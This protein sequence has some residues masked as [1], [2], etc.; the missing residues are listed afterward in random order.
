MTRIYPSEIAFTIPSTTFAFTSSGADANTALLAPAK[1]AWISEDV[2]FEG[3]VAVLLDPGSTAEHQLS[4][5]FA[6]IF[7]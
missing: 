1:A 6:A 4:A 7:R 5:A 3:F 2:K